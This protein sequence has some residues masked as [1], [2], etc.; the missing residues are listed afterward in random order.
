MGVMHEAYHP[1]KK[2]FQRYA[3]FGKTNSMRWNVATDCEINDDLQEMALYAHRH[4]SKA[5]LALLD[6]D[7]HPTKYNLPVNHLAEWYFN[8]LP[9]DA[10]QSGSDHGSAVDGH[11]KPWE[12]KDGE[13]GPNGEDLSGVPGPE[14]AAIIRETAEN[15]VQ[16]VQAGKLLLTRRTLSILKVADTDRRKGN[17]H[18]VHSNARAGTHL[19][20]TTS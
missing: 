19:R 15:I 12:V 8:N 13:T 2:H 9:E 16:A 1:F 7:P 3:A 20:R 17:D 10:D 6:T 4:E 18:D 11:A 5:L 14:L